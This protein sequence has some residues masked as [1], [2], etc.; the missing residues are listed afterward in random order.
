MP[1]EA[2]EASGS[3]CEA[4]Q[5]RGEAGTECLHVPAQRVVSQ[6]TENQCMQGTS[7]QEEQACC[8]RAVC[9]AQPPDA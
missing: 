7:A 9:F 1:A 2:G 6:E 8:N 5:L 3:V 4:V